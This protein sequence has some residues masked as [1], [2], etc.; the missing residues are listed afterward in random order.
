MDVRR[1]YQEAQADLARY[2]A[3]LATIQQKVAGLTKVVEGL[4]VLDPDLGNAA[5]HADGAG[6]SISVGGELRHSGDGAAADSSADHRLSIM[7]VIRTAQ[8]FM[9]TQEIV[10][11]MILGGFIEDDREAA[12][13]VRK[14]ISRMASAGHL[15]RER[16]DG[17]SYNYGLPG[18]APQNAESP[19]DT[20]LSVV[21]APTSD[22]GRTADV[23]GIGDRDDH[24]S[25]WNDDHGRGAPSVAEG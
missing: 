16:R 3:Q 11:A 17:R 18:M 4:R 9:S 19:A 1:I 2:Q 5:R 21:P 20:G 13:A 8:T 10:D 25:G 23:E 6:P 15:I 12:E 24:L 7:S 22:E 14:V